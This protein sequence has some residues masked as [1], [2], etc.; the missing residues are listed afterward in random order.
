VSH[1]TQ[2]TQLNASSAEE[3]AATAEEM[4]VNAEQLQQLMAFFKV[5][6]EKK[7][8]VLRFAPRK[9]VPVD[10]STA[11]KHPIP[12]VSGNLALTPTNEPDE[13]EFTRF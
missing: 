4:S 10:K 3:L 1:F 5:G 12:R 6:S 2:T 13:T 9:P 11:R 8:R 7:A